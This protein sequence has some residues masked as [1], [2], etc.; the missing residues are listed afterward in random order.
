MLPSK[1]GQ[2]IVLQDEDS[3]G[4]IFL[5]NTS[6]RAVHICGRTEPG[7]R[8]VL[9]NCNTARIIFPSSV[10]IFDLSLPR[11]CDTGFTFSFCDNIRSS[12]VLAE[13]CQPLISPS[14]HTP[15]Y[16]YAFLQIHRMVHLQASHRFQ[17]AFNTRI[18]LEGLLFS[19]HPQSPSS[20]IEIF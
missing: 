17:F 1:L 14:R 16:R 6:L 3:H 19:L 18:R 13:D 11:W 12:A 10:F 5:Q 2:P 4:A 7:D 20:T 15:K 9:L 8:G